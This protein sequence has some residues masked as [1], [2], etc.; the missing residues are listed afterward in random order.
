MLCGRIIF[1]GAPN[2]P[3][4]IQQ[5]LHK[6]DCAWAACKNPHCTSYQGHGAWCPVPDAGLWKQ[7]QKE[8]MLIIPLKTDE[9]GHRLVQDHTPAPVSTG[10]L[11]FAYRD[12]IVTWSP[13]QVV[14][15]TR[16]S[17]TE[18]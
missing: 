4:C 3:R 8:R 17:E 13:A 11:R 12:H 18:E 10:R 15:Y 6:G 5:A 2:G 7:I 1:S 9:P 14:T 16:P